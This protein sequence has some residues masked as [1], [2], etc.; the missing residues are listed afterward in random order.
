MSNVWVTASKKD[1]QIRQEDE[2][3]RN[4][5]LT[6][7]FSLIVIRLLQKVMWQCLWMLIRYVKL[8]IQTHLRKSYKHGKVAQLWERTRQT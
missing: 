2:A 3:E 1:S 4:L 7:G 5:Y 8:C 6:S